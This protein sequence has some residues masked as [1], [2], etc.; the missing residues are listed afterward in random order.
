MLRSVCLALF[1]AATPTLL[2]AGAAPTVPLRSRDQ[3]AVQV[4]F[5]YGDAATKTLANGSSI[6]FD[7]ERSGAFDAMLDRYR[8][9]AGVDSFKLDRPGQG[10]ISV[11]D[12]MT[13]LGGGQAVVRREEGSGVPG[14]CAVT[15]HIDAQRGVYSIAFDLETKTTVTLTG[16]GMAPQYT[17]NATG[18]AYES[19]DLPLPAGDDVIRGHAVFHPPI[20][21][22]HLGTNIV[23]EGR[24]LKQQEG[25]TPNPVHLRWQI[26]RPGPKPPL[27]LILAMEDHARWLPEGPTPASPRGA[28]GNT[29]TL[30]ATLRRKDGGPL[31]RGAVNIRFDLARS[32]TEPGVCLNFPVDAAPDP[33]DFD[34][35]FVAGGDAKPLGPDAQAAETPVGDWRQASVVLGAFDWGAYGNVTAIAY[36]PDYGDVLATVAGS[37]ARS[38]PMPQRAAGSNIGDAWKEQYGVTDR[39]DLDDTE[40]SP[41]NANDGD[42]FTLYEEY[43]GLIARGQ[44]SRRDADARLDPKRKNLV[45]LLAQRGRTAVS[46]AGGAAQSF[47]LQPVGGNLP[48]ALAGGRLLA[49]AIGD[50]H[51]VP[52]WQ[53]EAP[54]SRRMNANSAYGHHKPQHG[55]LLYA[56]NSGVAGDVG[57]AAPL[58]RRNKTPLTCDFVAVDFAAIAS[59]YAAQAAANAAGGIRTPYTLADELA[60]TVAH[61]LAHACGVPHHGDRESSSPTRQLDRTHVPPRYKVIGSDGTEVTAREHTVTNPDGTVTKKDYFELKGQIAGDDSRSSGDLTCLMCY[62]NYYTWRLTAI[63]G[64]GYVWRAMLPLPMGTTLCTARDGS[65]PNPHFGPAAAGRGNCRAKVKIRDE[66]N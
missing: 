22:G 65:P 59:G 15:V 29:A 56:L 23:P 55:V 26:G 39:A 19:G 17:P 46:G 11:G 21:G 13:F 52:V 49:G 42:G 16:P 30:T 35:R 6:R 18:V 24:L 36:V 25:G 10:S 37:G 41:G 40:K 63:R 60:N 7:S 12:T 2:P 1:L 58:E 43:R 8:A 48:A 45:L 33:K 50:A 57:V 28:P 38:L 62:P 61:E 47:N 9:Y 14:E 3:V 4:I 31:E 27:E 54:A 53:D 5:T 44:H 34:L 64:Q 51:V 32:S 66:A 20:G